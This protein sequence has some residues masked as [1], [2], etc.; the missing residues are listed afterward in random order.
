MSINLGSKPPD[1]GRKRILSRNPSTPLNITGN[2]SRIQQVL[3]YPRALCTIDNNDDSR[4]ASFCCAQNAAQQNRYGPDFGQWRT[5]ARIV[6][7]NNRQV[8]GTALRRRS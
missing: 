6:G 5:E 8:G 4:S 2:A 3:P 1:K 7:K